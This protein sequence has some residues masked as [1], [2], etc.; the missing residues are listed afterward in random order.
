MTVLFTT[1]S[2]L[3]FFQSQQGIPNYLTDDPESL[4]NRIPDQKNN[5]QCPNDLP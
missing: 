2:L 5:Y 4:D 3:H 1:N